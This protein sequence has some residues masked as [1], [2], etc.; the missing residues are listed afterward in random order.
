MPD[1]Q[2]LVGSKITFIDDEPVEEIPYL[3][4]TKPMTL[5]VEFPIRPMNVETVAILFGM[6]LYEASL[7]FDNHIIR[8]NN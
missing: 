4:F 6:S 3:D 2:H 5:E 8:S 1:F 7:I